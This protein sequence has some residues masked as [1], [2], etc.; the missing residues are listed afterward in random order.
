MAEGGTKT[1]VDSLPTCDFCG[2]KA[3]YDAQTPTGQWANLCPRCFTGF[4]CS[5]GTGRGQK[6]VVRSE[7]SAPDPSPRPSEDD[8]EQMVFDGECT[9]TDGCVVDPDG[10]CEHGKPSWLLALGLI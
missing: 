3:E 9:A 4:G 8:L 1:Y 2:R 6:L 10:H 5:L 7:K